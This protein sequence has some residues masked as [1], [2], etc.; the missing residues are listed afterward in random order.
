MDLETVFS[1][2]NTAILPG[3]LL[4][5]FAPR[6][7]WTQRIATGTAAALALV[8]LIAIV[9]T[10][11]KGE[12]GFGSLHDVA[13]LFARREVL[14][15]GWIHYLVFDLFTGAWEVRDAAR[16]RIPHVLVVPCLV[17]TLLFGPVGFLAYLVLRAAL[18]RRLDVEETTSVEA[19]APR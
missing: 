11:G 12:G 10:F 8:Y 6:W 18:R 1:I 16:L 17:L 15:V 19:P 14:L 13:Q 7:R 5:A 4:L 3:W 2:C 9:P